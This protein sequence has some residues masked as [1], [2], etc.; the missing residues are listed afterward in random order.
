MRGNQVEIRPAE[1]GKTRMEHV[2]NVKYILPAEKYIEQL[3]EY[4][5]F[6]CKS[7][8]R[9]NPDKIPDLNWKWCKELNITSV[10][11]TVT[12]NTVYIG[13]ILKSQAHLDCDCNLVA[14][15]M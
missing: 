7:R 3:P 11:Q 10:G 2:S 12:I 4:E 14:S 8:L 1:G 5:N 6:G 13:T 9:L 15:P